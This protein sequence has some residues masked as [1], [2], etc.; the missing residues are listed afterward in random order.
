MDVSRIWLDE[1]DS[2]TKGKVAWAKIER[3]RIEAG[4]PNG[5]PAR[6][7]NLADN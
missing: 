1:M 6:S 5:G 4:S 2:K 3:S 7:R